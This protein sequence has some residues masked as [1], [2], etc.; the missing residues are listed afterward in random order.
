[1]IANGGCEDLALP[2]VSM[3]WSDTHEINVSRWWNQGMEAAAAGNG[4]G[5]H[6]VL[7]LNDDVVAR[8]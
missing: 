4:P 1:M 7:L 2:G 6:N 3:V 5:T 8:S